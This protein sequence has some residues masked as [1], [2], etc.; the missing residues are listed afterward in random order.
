MAHVK[1]AIHNLQ[2]ARPNVLCGWSI[3]APLAGRASRHRFELAGE[4]ILHINR[5]WGNN[6]IDID[7]PHAWFQISVSCKGNLA[8]D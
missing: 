5:M 2:T 6:R 1:I 3:A 7:R 8:W 4:G